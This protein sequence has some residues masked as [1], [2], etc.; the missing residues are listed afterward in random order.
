M[1]DKGRTN[2]SSITL[3]LSVDIFI[4]GPVTST[5]RLLHSSIILL[6]LLEDEIQSHPYMIIT[7]LLFSYS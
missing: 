6:V 5:P 3:Y 7:N 2:L 4:I 1:R